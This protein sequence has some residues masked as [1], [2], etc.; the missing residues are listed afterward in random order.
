VD[1]SPGSLK[2]TSHGRP[3]VVLKEEGM[4]MRT[5]LTEE[6][7]GMRVKPVN[8]IMVRDGP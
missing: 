7:E 6:K 5:M 3:E 8:A 4:L 2:S 1:E